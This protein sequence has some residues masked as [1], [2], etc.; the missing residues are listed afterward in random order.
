MS[1]K[2]LIEKTQLTNY[3]QGAVSIQSTW[4]PE[5]TRRIWTTQ[6]MDD[7]ASLTPSLWPLATK[8]PI[9]EPPAING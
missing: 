3:R 4:Q 6:I 8:S 9:H 7:Q 5:K 2:H 1:N